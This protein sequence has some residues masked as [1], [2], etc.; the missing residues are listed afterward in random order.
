[1]RLIVRAVT[2]IRGERNWFREEL[3]NPINPI[4]HILLP[5]VCF[6]TVIIGGLLLLLSLDQLP[7]VFLLIMI[8]VIYLIVRAIVDAWSMLIQLAVFKRNRNSVLNA[9]GEQSVVQEHSPL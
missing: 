9:L 6:L 3:R 4:A 7:T 8:A 2:V 5:G 1:M